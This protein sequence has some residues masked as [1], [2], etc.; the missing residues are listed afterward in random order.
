MGEPV[1][2]TMG[3]VG[4]LVDYTMVRDVW[5]SR[6]TIRWLGMCG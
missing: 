6:W 3:C 1:D 2:Y 5:V 4:E